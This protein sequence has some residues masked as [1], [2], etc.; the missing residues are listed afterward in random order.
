MRNANLAPKIQHVH[1]LHAYQRPTVMCNLQGWV[2]DVQ[3]QTTEHEDQQ[4][5]EQEVNVGPRQRSRNVKQREKPQRNCTNEGSD[6]SQQQNNLPE[7]EA[8]KEPLTLNPSRSYGWREGFIDGQTATIRPSKG[9]SYPLL[10][11]TL[12]SSGLVCTRRRNSDLPHATGRKKGQKG[13]QSQYTKY[14]I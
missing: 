10:F 6:K 2:S 7:A 11:V 5:G 12:F 4:D 9:L 13:H 8:R 14:Y 1:K 3:L